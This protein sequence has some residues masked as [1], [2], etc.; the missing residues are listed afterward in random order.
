MN[1]KIRFCLGYAIP[2]IALLMIVT[3]PPV[4]FGAQ[5]AEEG[6]G[7]WWSAFA[8]SSL[9]SERGAVEKRIGAPDSE[10]FDDLL[11]ADTSVYALERGDG[12]FAALRGVVYYIDGIAHGLSVVY[13]PS[14]VRQLA[15]FALE[16]FDDILLY[17]ELSALA[18]DG[19]D[20]GVL[21]AFTSGRSGDTRYIL[22]RELYSRMA[23]TGDLPSLPPTHGRKG[24]AA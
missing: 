10:I 15:R 6:T 20:C 13:E 3:A 5:V 18:G 11:S 2:V 14:G 4:V 19:Y 23:R 7:I 1:F 8:E 24:Y 21:A 16:N 12:P 22:T 17:G 9:M